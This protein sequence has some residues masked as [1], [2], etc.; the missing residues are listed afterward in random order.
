MV[1]SLEKLLHRGLEKVSDEIDAYRDPTIIW[2]TNNQVNNS[3]G[4]LTLHLCGNLQHF[5]G[6]ILGQS[7]YERNREREFNVKNLSSNEINKE[8][9]DTKKAISDTL[10]QL[11]NSTLQEK[12]PIEV[13]GFEMTVEY[14]LLH[15]HGH[16][17]YH[18]GQISYH[19]RLLDVN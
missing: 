13:L 15:L 6:H 5:I 3:S 18:L 11:D 10:Q 16:L 2:T 9:E 12:Y 7:R 14:F 4:N 17:N 8:I 19:R 1:S